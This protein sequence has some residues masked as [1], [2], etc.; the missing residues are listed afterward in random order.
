[1][2]KPTIYRKPMGSS[3]FEEEF[4]MEAL[5]QMG[6]P[7]ERLSSL[8]DFEMFRAVLEDV[9]L[10]KEC[11]T[12]AGRKPIDVVLMFRVIFSSTL[13]W[14]GRPSDSVPDYRPYQFP[15]IPWNSHRG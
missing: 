11:K 9:L 10:A 4:T 1:M 14:L 3:L 6:N 12:P 2:D 13:L 5:S 7:L 8:V 15:P